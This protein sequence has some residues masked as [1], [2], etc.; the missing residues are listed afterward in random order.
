MKLSMLIFAI[1]LLRHVHVRKD[2]RLSP[3]FH[4]ASDGKL[5]GAGNE[6]IKGLLLVQT[7]SYICNVLSDFPCHMRRSLKCKESRC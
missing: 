6:A 7:H 5:G 4:I 1:F 2:T 3:L